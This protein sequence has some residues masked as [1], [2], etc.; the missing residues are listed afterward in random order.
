MGQCV[1]KDCG[2]EYQKTKVENGVPFAEFFKEVP[3]ILLNL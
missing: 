2:F 1:L 3:K